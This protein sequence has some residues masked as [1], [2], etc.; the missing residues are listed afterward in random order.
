MYYFVG[1]RPNATTLVQVYQPMWIMRDTCLQ[2]SPVGRS[3]VPALVLLLRGAALGLRVAIVMG[4]LEP[5]S[6]EATLYIE[7]LVRLGAVQDALVAA[8]LLGDEVEGLDDAQA[9][10]LALLVLCDGNVLD[11][12][13]EPQLVDELALHDQRACADN[14]VGAVGDAEEEVFVVALGHPFVALVPLLRVGG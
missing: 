4:H 11:V 2:P 7:A 14:L 12:A 8:D 13:D 3:L 10:L 9:E 5:G 6:P 1:G